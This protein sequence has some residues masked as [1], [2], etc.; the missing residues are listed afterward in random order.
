MRP[1]Y[2]IIK[3]RIREDFLETLGDAS[4]LPSE[5]KLQE[6]YGVSRP[7]I[8]KAL[9]ALTG[10][11]VLVRQLRRGNFVTAQS[12]A[13]VQTTDSRRIGFIAPLAGEELVQRCFRGIDRIAHRRGY[14]LVMGNAGNSVAREEDTVRDLLGTGVMGL[15]ITPVPRRL[16]EISS[17][18]L[19]QNLGVPYAL[20]DTCLPA[21]GGIQVM[22]DNRQ[23]GYAMT[24]WLIREGYSQIA[25][26]TYTEEVMHT[27]L[28]DRLAGYRDALSDFGKE[29]KEVLIARLDTQFDHEAALIAILDTWK[30]IE[31]PPTAIIAPD[32]MLAM[33]LITLLRAHGGYVSEKLRIVGFDNRSVARHFYPPIPTSDPD[34]ERL[35]E[36]ACRL[37]LD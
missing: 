34:F 16:K 26:I 6:L 15:L 10:E 1:Q 27:P 21:Q 33:E 11:G 4:R 20:V 3:E 37:L 30:N 14:Q 7:T 9:A 31:N 22:F 8:S 25:L 29:A 36:T 2:E 12:I 28:A 35:G 19:L 32:D 17:D 5:R 13:Q 23:L 24:E 18:Y